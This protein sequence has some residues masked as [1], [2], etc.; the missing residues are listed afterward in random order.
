MFSCV[1]NLKKTPI[2]KK[3]NCNWTRN[4]TI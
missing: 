2:F 1:E 3:I 4:F